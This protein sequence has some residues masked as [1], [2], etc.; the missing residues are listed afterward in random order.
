M[1]AQ[2]PSILPKVILIVL[3]FLNIIAAGVM[4]YYAGMVGRVRLEWERALEERRALRDGLTTDKLI[5][6]LT[7]D[8][9]ESI[10]RW[11]A[12]YTRRKTAASLRLKDL[13]EKPELVGKEDSTKA[14]REFG[15]ED[16]R[17]VLH[18]FIRL[19]SPELQAEEQRLVEEKNT[20]LQ[21]SRKYDERIAR[22]QDEIAKFA[23]EEGRPEELLTKERDILERLN[24]ENQQRRL[25]LA[26]QYAELE[27]A[28]AAREL[29]EGILADY[30][31]RRDAIRE[32][33]AR[34]IEE[35]LRLEQEIAELE[36]T[37]AR[38]SAR[39]GE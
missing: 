9:K 38:A 6:Q 13:K 17:R 12:D 19:R 2:K 5:A 29:A 30:K 35:N 25:E 23:T 26:Q 20:L 7:P 4:F 18:E 3:S 24:V 22:L 8:E 31:R 32:K 11:Q 36:K 1:A 33:A 15:P 28:V 14:A 16:Y 21:I 39:R 10:Q 34:I 27:E 37:K